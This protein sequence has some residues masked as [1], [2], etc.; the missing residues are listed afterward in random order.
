MKRIKSS[1]LAAALM[2]TA[3]QPAL[4]APAPV[5]A[6]SIQ[7]A[8]RP[9]T[10][11][12]WLLLEEGPSGVSP[13]SA[14]DFV[15]GPGTPPIGQGSI[16]LTVTTAISDQV[17]QVP[18]FGA[19]LGDFTKLTYATHVNGPNAATRLQ[20]TVDLTSTDSITGTP[21]RLVFDPHLQGANVVPGLWQEWDALNGLWWAT[22]ETGPLAAQCTQSVP[23]PLNVILGVYPYLGLHS[24]EG[25]YTLQARASSSAYTTFVDDLIVGINGN[26]AVYNFEPEIPC[27]TVCWVDAIKGNDRFGGSSPVAAK[28][29]IQAGID[30]VS[31]LGKVKVR[32]G[33]YDEIALARTR[34]NGSGPHTFGLFV[35]VAKSGITVEGVDEGNN[36]IRSAGAAKAFVTTNANNPFGPTGVLIEG[37]NV[38]ITG[39]S[40][41]AN[42]PPAAYQIDAI[43]ENVT[44]RYND[45]SVLQGRVR[46]HDPRYVAASNTPHITKFAIGDNRFTASGV[47]EIANGV[48]ATGDRGNRT[49]LDNQFVQTTTLASIGIFGPN[50]G[51]PGHVHPVGGAVIFGNAFVNT[52]PDDGMHIQIA[53]DYDL[54]EFYFPSYWEGNTYN[55]AVLVGP[56]PPATQRALPRSENGFAL[57]NVRGIGVSIQQ[58]I[59]L[60]NPGDIIVI[61]PGEYRETL[62]ITQP[63][64]LQGAGTGSCA[65][66]RAVQPSI[67][68]GATPALPLITVQS[69][70]VT[71][72]GFMLNAS[73][74]TAAWIAVATPGTTG[75]RFDRLRF[76]NN[77][78]IGN[79]DGVPGG[80]WLQNQDDLLIECN[81]FNNLGRDAVV[82]EPA[83]PSEDGSNH[84]VYRNN[85]SVSTAGWHFV[86]RGAGHRDV[87]IRDNRAI[88]DGIY[89][90]NVMGLKLLR[91]SYRGGVDGASG[92]TLVNVAQVEILDN[93]F[94]N[95]RG[96]ALLLPAAAVS[97][98][99]SRDLTITNNTVNA[100]AN[101]TPGS[102]LFDL[103]GLDG[104]NVINSNVMTISGSTPEWL[105]GVALSGTLGSVMVVSNTLSAG[106]ADTT[107]L[108]PSAG[109]LMQAS[110]GAGSAITVTRN[111]IA[112]FTAAVHGAAIPSGATVSV[113]RNDLSGSVFALLNSSQNALDARCNWYGAGSG[114]AAGTISGT[115]GI[116]PWLVGPDL[117]SSCNAPRLTVIH[118][119]SGKAPDSSWVLNGP[120][121]S[122]LM[123]PAGGT[124]LIDDAPAGP[125]V[126]RM[127]LPPGYTARA[128]CTSG[129][130]GTSIV[131]IYLPVN[132]AVS[133]TFTISA[134]FGPGTIFL[135][136][137][138]Q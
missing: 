45:F 63:I 65:K 120:T 13:S 68:R 93:Q 66:G 137:V 55:R 78:F 58:G 122:S 134:G 136:F 54:N 107:S 23:C 61:K 83:S 38:T 8:I 26:N 127:Q 9:S 6:A 71:I 117:E 98:A 110:N 135:P 104:I 92:A 75:Q 79:P 70:D 126:L 41:G 99:Q 128:V 21:G 64:T 60:A 53:G 46:I 49:I 62:F 133:C 103:N 95:P 123:S 29:S 90:E 28:R 2:V 25:A 130:T 42:T 74:S 94:I 15:F 132:G 121:G 89:L 34:Y 20:I 116:S 113:T 67:I 3:L 43:G 11:E 59:S 56:T 125:A 82:V 22:A 48:G 91:N 119:V 17:A 111:S 7:V 84:V 124:T 72:D 52:G 10:Q 30:S 19:L 106:G 16:Q 108:S 14:A 47:L 33:S 4:S 40:F 129:A 44:L 114:P 77:E 112:G 32:P 39:L 18:A 31:A 85:D 73:G 76:L 88:E 86:L 109:V 87:W 57:N 27:T 131:N 50:S 81:Y 69:G 96:P 1:L 36:P 138:R 35:P 115:V 37:D 5:Q 100:V 51:V 24:T 102:A 105:H 97:L 101:D 12:G 80:L 118:V